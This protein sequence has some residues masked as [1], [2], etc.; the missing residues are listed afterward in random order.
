MT[1][2]KT[3]AATDA[4]RTYTSVYNASLTE[5][6]TTYLPEFNRILDRRCTEAG[7]LSPAQ[8]KAR[9][10][11]EAALKKAESAAKAEKRRVD[12]IAALEAKLA[13][14]KGDDAAA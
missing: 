11:A 2:K 13:A 6:R 10:E 8:R 9:S 1:D 3:T 7:I 12:Q 14:L 4:S 5:L